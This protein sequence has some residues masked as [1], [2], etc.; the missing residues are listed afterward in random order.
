MILNEAVIRRPFGGNAVMA[1]QL[2]HVMEV[3][4]RPNVTVRIV[5][6]SAGGHGG[7]NAGAS[8]TSRKT[9]GPE[10]CWNHHW[11]TWTP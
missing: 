9:L 11:P 5:P 8:W 2:A 10:N 1:A 6:F 4:Q 7:A 3:T